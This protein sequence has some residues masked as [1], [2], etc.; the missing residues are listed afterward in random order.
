[1]HHPSKK[2]LQPLYRD[3]APSKPKVHHAT[4]Y[5]VTDLAEP[6]GRALAGGTDTQEADD[7]QQHGNS[8]AHNMIDIM[9]ICSLA[10]STKRSTVDYSIPRMAL[11]ALH[12]VSRFIIA[13]CLAATHDIHMICNI[14]SQQGFRHVTGQESV[15]CKLS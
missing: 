2:V 10:S 7:N 6:E 15:S 1:M 11:Y 13:S 3:S 14:A 5:V 9:I 8:H 4:H 12:V